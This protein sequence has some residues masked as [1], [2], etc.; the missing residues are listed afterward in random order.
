MTK[1][2]DSIKALRRMIEV[3]VKLRFLLPPATKTY[4]AR[5]W[6]LYPTLSQAQPA[7]VTSPHLT[8]KLR[9]PMLKKMDLLNLK[10]NLHGEAQFNIKKDIIYKQQRLACQISGLMPSDHPQAGPSLA[11]L[12][13]AQHCH[14]HV[15]LVTRSN[16][17]DR[18]YTHLSYLT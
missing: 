4:E 1:C 16:R 11:R 13:V 17:S 5:M 15:D 9:S 18:A 14:C 10:T 2:L 3:E 12:S 6:G 8:L 7:K